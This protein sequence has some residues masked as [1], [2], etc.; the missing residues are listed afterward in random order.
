MSSAEIVADARV[1]LA[2]KSQS[3]RVRGSSV[4]LR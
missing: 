2:A 1:S 3:A 4:A